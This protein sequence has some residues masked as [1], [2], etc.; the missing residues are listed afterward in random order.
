[1]GRGLVMAGLLALLAVAVAAALWLA[2][3]GEPRE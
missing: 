3:F 2:S 1:V